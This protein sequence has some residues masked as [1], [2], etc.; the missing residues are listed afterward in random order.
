MTDEKENGTKLK[1]KMLSKR[2]LSDE[3]KALQDFS[4][5][6]WLDGNIPYQYHTLEI[7]DGKNELEQL[8]INDIRALKNDAVWLRRTMTETAG[9]RR[10][11]IEELKKENKHI[12]LLATIMMYLFVAFKVVKGKRK[13]QNGR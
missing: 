5:K 10:S 11:Q 2:P 7:E 8:M 3:P 1:L 13:G 9:R 12:K 4:E 6:Y